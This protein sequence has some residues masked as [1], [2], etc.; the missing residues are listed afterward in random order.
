MAEENTTALSTIAD[1]V[2]TLAAPAQTTFLR[3]ASRIL[4][5]VLAVPAA[6]LRRPAQQVEDLTDARSTVSHGLAAALVEHSKNDPDIMRAVAESYLPNEI[7]KALNKYRTVATAAEEYEKL[8]GSED[9]LD[10]D[11]DWINRFIRFSEDASS[12]RLQLLFGKILAGEIIHAGSYS[13][14]TLRTVSELT[15]SLADDFAWAWSKNI[16]NEIWNGPDLGKGEAWNRLVR[17]R[18]AGFL[19]PIESGI[20]QPFSG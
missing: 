17:L 13:P 2:T 5:G 7:R 9:D 3:A 14:A 10:L 15:Q 1:A 12:E 11:D 6:W 8:G 18:D 20:H 16:E 4:G 19:S